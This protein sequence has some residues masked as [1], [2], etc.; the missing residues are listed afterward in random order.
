MLL[1]LFESELYLLQFILTAESSNTH[2]LL[3]MI[4]ILIFRHIFFC[5][6]LKKCLVNSAI[7]LARGD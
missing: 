3:S 6:A 1:A 2:R 7:L 5:F 4:M